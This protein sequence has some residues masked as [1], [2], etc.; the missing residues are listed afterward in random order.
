MI[1]SVWKYR[2]QSKRWFKKNIIN[3]N[4]VNIIAVD[5][6]D[7]FPFSPAATLLDASVFMMSDEHEIHIDSDG[8]KYQLPQSRGYLIKT[9]CDGRESDIHLDHVYN[10]L[11]HIDALLTFTKINILEN[12]NNFNIINI[13]NN[14]NINRLFSLIST[15]YQTTKSNWLLLH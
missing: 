1:K 10:G 6:G 13:N 14:E 2:G 12:S 5:L 11:K 7:I 3:T 4:D 15:Q 8:I 9:D